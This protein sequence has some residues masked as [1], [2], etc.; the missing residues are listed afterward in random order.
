M[1]WQGQRESE[2][3][4]DRGGSLGGKGLI[5]GGG[6]IGTILIVLACWA[7]GIDPS[8]L[9]EGKTGDRRSGPP[10]AVSPEEATQKKFVRVILASTEDVWTEVFRKQLGKQYR[11][12]KLV[13]FSGQVQSACGLASSAVGPF[14]CPGDEKVYLDLSFFT[15]LRN[16][17]KVPGEFADGYVIA[18]EIGHHV[19]RLLGYPENHPKPGETKNQVSVRIELQADFLAGIWG[20]YAKD[21]FKLTADDLTSAL[22][23]ANAIGDDKLQS[24]AK[25]YVVPE[26]FTH[27]SSKQRVFW[28]RRG[29][30]EGRVEVMEELFTRPYN[31]L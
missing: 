6:G 17:F 25:G 19:Q 31:Q 4:E 13:E 16:R 29:F 20:H 8:A 2:N 1:D 3:V 26:N 22:T 12:P 27:G 10:A 21:Q 14:Y 5:I 9:F 15:E 11:K 7:F 18:H 24:E 30:E 28:L 23:A